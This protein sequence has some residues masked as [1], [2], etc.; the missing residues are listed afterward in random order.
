MHS[1][2]PPWDRANR[3]R[4]LGQVPLFA[5]C[6]P[7]RG[8]LLGANTA[9]YMSAAPYLR[10]SHSLISDTFAAPNRNGM[11]MGP[12]PMAGNW[13]FSSMGRGS[14]SPFGTVLTL[15]PIKDG[16]WPNRIPVIWPYSLYPIRSIFR[17]RPG[18]GP[19]IYLLGKQR[20]AKGPLRFGA[21]RR[22][23]VTAASIQAGTGT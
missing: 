14:A 10:T 2:G 19:P 11:L 20:F 22:I 16:H 5:R 13:P 3:R 21:A 6:G 8:D 1:H 15:R 18:K 7:R 4:R 23:V 17:R 12:M 9:H